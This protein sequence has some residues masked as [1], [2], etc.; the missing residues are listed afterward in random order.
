MN[1]PRRFRNI[2]KVG[3]KGAPRGFATRLWFHSARGNALS[4]SRSADE[5]GSRGA[6]KSKERLPTRD[7]SGGSASLEM[8]P[9]QTTHF[10]PCCCSFNATAFSQSQLRLD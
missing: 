4:P 9:Q 6:G 1:E 8:G 10:L 2:R 3:E 5:G 7:H